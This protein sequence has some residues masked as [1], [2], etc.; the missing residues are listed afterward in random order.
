MATLYQQGLSVKDIARQSGRSET[1]VRRRL[2][3]MGVSM[4][5]PATG[6]A[7]VVLSDCTI[8]GRPLQT[9]LRCRCGQ[10]I[11]EGH[12]DIGPLCAGC[13]PRRP[14]L[15]AAGLA[16]RTWLPVGRLVAGVE[17]D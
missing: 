14:A 8:C 9:H 10:L 3:E 17:I 6:Q 13:R 11:G 4:R 5:P 15:G 2:R 7:R 1:T 12:R 16:R